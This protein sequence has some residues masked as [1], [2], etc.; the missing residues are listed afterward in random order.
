MHSW[1]SIHERSSQRYIRLL[2]SSSTHSIY[3]ACSTTEWLAQTCC[4]DRSCTAAGSLS[5]L[6]LLFTASCDLPAVMQHREMSRQ[7]SHVQWGNYSIHLLW[8]ETP[9]GAVGP[10]GVVL[11][12]RKAIVPGLYLV[13]QLDYFED[14]NEG[15]LSV[16]EAGR[17]RLHIPQSPAHQR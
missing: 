9:G 10:H 17:I 4:S 16:D 5:L 1:S 12:Q 14:A 2:V 11:E 15:S 6:C 13:K 7:L 8:E 3:P